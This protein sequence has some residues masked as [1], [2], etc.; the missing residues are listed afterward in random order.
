MADG[1]LTDTVHYRTEMPEKK[2]HKSYSNMITR[3]HS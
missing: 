1:V 2:E 3:L